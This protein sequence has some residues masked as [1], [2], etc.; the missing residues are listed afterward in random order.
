CQC[1][2]LVTHEQLIRGV[3]PRGVH[4][5]GVADS[6]AQVEIVGAPCRN[7]DSHALAVDLVDRAYLRV[8]R[9]KVSGFD[10]E[11]SGGG[12]D[13]RSACA[14]PAAMGPTSR[15]ATAAASSRGASEEMSWSAPPT[16]AAFSPAISGAM[17]CGSPFGARPVTSR[18]FDKLMPARSTPFGASSLTSAGVEVTGIARTPT[19]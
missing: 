16:T 17:P 12:G 3:K 18:K 11:I 1:V 13:L 15:S 10:L 5:L 6:A 9:D 14:G 7:R 8:S 4:Q 2:E 19:Q